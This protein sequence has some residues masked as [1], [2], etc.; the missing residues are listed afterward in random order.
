MRILCQFFLD[1]PEQMAKNTVF[2]KAEG[3]VG[4]KDHT[5]F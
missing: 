4:W 2:E 3:E 5:K 1:H